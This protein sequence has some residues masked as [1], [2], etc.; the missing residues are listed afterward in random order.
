MDSYRGLAEDRSFVIKPGYKGSGVV[1]WDRTDYLLGMEKHLSDSN[2]YKEVKFGDNE[3][4]KLVDESNRMFKKLFSKCFS[5]EECKYF[6]YSSKKSTNLEKLY[7]F[8]LKYI[9]DCTM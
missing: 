3:L 7:F 6:P 2:T 8:C 5:R 1:V 4:V 9:K